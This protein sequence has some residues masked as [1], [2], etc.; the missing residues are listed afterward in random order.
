MPQTHYMEDVFKLNGVPDVTFVRPVEFPRLLV[1]LR[2]HGRGVVIEGPSGIGKTS[3]VTKALEELGI[4]ADVLTLSARKKADLELIK[5]LPEIV[6][7]GFV[8]IEDFHRLDSEIKLRIADHLKVLADEEREDTKI[9][10]IGI[11]RGSR[12]HPILRGVSRL[13]NSRQIPTIESKN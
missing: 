6:A 13:S 4:Q 7:A 10:V 8:V 5:E 1:A 12:S 2:T 11:N 3:A 9:V